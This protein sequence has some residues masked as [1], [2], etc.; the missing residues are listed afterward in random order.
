M[1]ALYV[2]LPLA[3]AV[4]ALANLGNEIQSQCSVQALNLQ[5]NAKDIAQG[6]LVEARQ[7]KEYFTG[8]TS[9]RSEVAADRD[10]LNHY[11]MQV[12]VDRKSV[13]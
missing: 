13:V 3:F 5:S 10:S 9:S 7:I 8:Q 2:L 6:R 12:K 1:K 11:R 4:P